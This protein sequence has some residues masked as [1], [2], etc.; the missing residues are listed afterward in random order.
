M[1][2]TESTKTAEVVTLHPVKAKRASER[3]WSKPV[4][5]LGFCIIPSLL[6]RGQKR[7]GV[8]AAQLA[9]LMHL[10]DYWWDVDRKPFPTKA[11]LGERMGLSARQ[12]QRYVAEL[13]AMGLVKRIARKAVHKGRLSNEYDLSGLVDRLRALAPEFKAA[14]EEA[15]AKRRAVTRPGLK[16]KA[17]ATSA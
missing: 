16:P 9:V 4:M 10:A 12:A 14:E 8:N 13:E 1:S 7:L 15:R 6:L 11:T 17:I 2:D 3:K 5:D